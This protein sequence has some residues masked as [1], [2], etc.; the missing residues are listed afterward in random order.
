MVIS[1]LCKRLIIF[2]QVIYPQQKCKAGF[3]LFIDYSV[4]VLGETIAQAVEVMYVS[5]VNVCVS[6]IF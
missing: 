1:I 4:V 3:M 2:E 6:F 5:F